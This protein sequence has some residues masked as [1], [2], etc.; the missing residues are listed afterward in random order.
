MTFFNTYG[1][2]ILIIIGLLICAGLVVCMLMLKKIKAGLGAKKFNIRCLRCCEAANEYFSIYVT[3]T[4]MHDKLLDNF[5]IE[6]SGHYL[7][8]GRL[9]AI[10]KNE[11]G[12]KKALL[13]KQRSSLVFKI[14]V[15]LL[16]NEVFAIAERFGLSSV[17][18]YAVDGM[19][20]LTSERATELERMLKKDR[21]AGKRLFRIFGRRGKHPKDRST[22][23]VNHSSGENYP[24]TNNGSSTLPVSV[25]EVSL[26]P[27]PTFGERV[28]NIF[29]KK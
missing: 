26:P 21:K 20:L 9:S 2:F 16:E 22:E 28:K 19:G 25:K 8:L 29:K 7:D 17:K 12:E 18:L 13:V 24:S 5:G 3:N 6:V 10:A 27:V 23:N 1:N 15:I 11:N 4:S 14:D